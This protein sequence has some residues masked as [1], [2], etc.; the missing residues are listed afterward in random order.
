LE[1]YSLGYAQDVR[2]A[3]FAGAKIGYL[4]VCKRTRC[5][6]FRLASVKNPAHRYVKNS[7]HIVIPAKADTSDRGIHLSGYSESVP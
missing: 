4:P 1:A 2:Y 5:V 3:D 6:R 7:I